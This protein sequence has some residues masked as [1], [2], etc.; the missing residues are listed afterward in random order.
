MSQR[1]FHKKSRHGCSQCK[2]NRTKCDERMPLC[3]R[4]RR[5][6]ATCSLADQ[7]SGLLFVPA[8]YPGPH[9]EHSRTEMPSSTSAPSSLSDECSSSAAPTSDMDKP[10]VE[11]QFSYPEK[12]RLRLMNHY[13]LHAS[14]SITEVILPGEQD[15]SMWGDWVA[16][17]A[18]DYDFLLHGLL[19]ISALHLALCGISRQKHIVM[20]IHHHNLGVALFRP[21]LLS[22]THENHDAVF[23]FSCVVALY[24]FGIQRCS[25][26]LE[27]PLTNIY[28]VLILVRG[29]AIALKPNYEARAQSRWSVL[30]L[31]YPF[32]FTGN[33]PGRIEDMLRSLRQ[34]IATTSS[35]LS[36]AG[37]Y[38]SAIQ[39]LRDTLTMTLMYR[40]QKMT[41]S[42]FPSLCPPEFWEMVR[43]AD[44]LALAILANYVITLHWMRKNIWMQG[45]GKETVDAIRQALPPEWQECIAWAVQE[46]EH[47]S[48]VVHYEIEP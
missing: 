1:R 26:S 38:H 4:C 6:G 30:M 5:I 43:I 31:P 9:E 2:R 23:A 8:K 27:D 3:G 7:P 25:E 11:F 32:V 42:Y 35:A 13:A 10:A 15:Q 34:R 46:I 40:R 33:L 19:S 16:E 14:K 36:S 20:A 12:E 18:F 17:L 21:H 41:L 37:I 28:Q 29:S 44:P 39:A 45:W 22:I 48:E 47:P 24:S